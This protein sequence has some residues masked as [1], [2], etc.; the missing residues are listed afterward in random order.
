MRPFLSFD[1]IHWVQGGLNVTYG[2]KKMR[3]DFLE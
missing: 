3:Y 2:E 1:N